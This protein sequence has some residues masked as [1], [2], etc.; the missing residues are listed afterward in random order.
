MTISTSIAALR[1]IART[2]LGDAAPI[3]IEPAGDGISTAVYRLR[4][5]AET[6]YLRILP[7]AAQSFAPEARVHALLRERGVRVPAVIY[8]EDC[9][10]LLERSVMVTTEIPGRPAAEAPRGG[11]LPAILREAGRDLAA[12]NRIPVEGFGWIRRAGSAAN[13]L[14]AEMADSRSFLLEDLD[15][16]LATLSGAALTAKQVRQVRELVERH[17]AWLD[18]E[19]AH[20]AHGDFDLTHIYQHD[21]RYTGIIDFGEIRGTGPYHDL[22]HF[23]LHDGEAGSGEGLPFLLEGYA[24]ISPLP[25]DAM[26]RISFLSLLIGLRFLGRGLGGLMAHPLSVQARQQVQGAIGREL[27]SFEGMWG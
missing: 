11:T 15:R 17:A 2:A 19:Q 18:I 27:R 23:R 10:L 9:H 24:E 8:L 20:L 5:G 16:H 25:P 1:D 3:D 22:G 7:E 4:R 26:P 12:I 6:F 13:G 14:E 21:G